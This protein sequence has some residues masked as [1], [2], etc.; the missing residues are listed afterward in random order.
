MIKKSRRPAGIWF[1]FYYFIIL[2]FVLVSC[3]SEGN[4]QPLEPEVPP[5]VDTYNYVAI[6]NDGALF[7]IGNETGIIEQVGK[8]DGITFNLNF[9]TVTSSKSKTYMYEQMPE[10]FPGDG[11][12]T[13]FRGQICELDNKTLESKCT[14]LDF[15]DP[16]IPEFSGLIALDWDEQNQNLIG[17]VRDVTTESKEEP[18]YLVRIDP[19]TLTIS[20]T[21]LQFEQ[22]SIIST[23]LVGQTYYVSSKYDDSF[24]SK[25]IFS[26]VNLIDGTQHIIDTSNFDQLP[27]ILSASGDGKK[28]LGFISEY[29]PGL[30]NASIP[31]IYD[32]GSGGFENMSTP[33]RLHLTNGYGKSFY[34]A[35]KSEQ[36][37]LIAN[38]KGPGIMKYRSKENTIS[39]LPLAPLEND[40]SS[41]IAIINLR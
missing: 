32:L 3:S 29:T 24:F 8:I 25:S 36:V 9:N 1:N 23:C 6:R 26:A 13:G 17:I 39:V 10:I 11:P 2:L 31:I 4:E 16:A 40:L 34:D 15:S 18:N 28:I 21:G 7:E 27:T 12:S 5:V 33:M 22:T 41:L 38:E 14:I 37:V 19:K 30:F 20:Y 35:L